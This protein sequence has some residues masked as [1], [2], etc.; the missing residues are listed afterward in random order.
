MEQ[1]HSLSWP[2]YLQEISWGPSVLSGALPRKRPIGE[3]PLST[4][5][6]WPFLCDLFS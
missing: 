2:L 4:F 5:V 6:L 1:L 3:M